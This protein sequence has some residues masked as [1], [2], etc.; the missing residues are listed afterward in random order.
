M[1]CDHLKIL[2]LA[3][4]GEWDR[5]H[6]LIQPYSDQNSCLIHA[7]L[8]RI[9][10]DLSNAQYWYNRAELSMP[11]NTLEQELERLYLLVDDTNK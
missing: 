5:A 3:K 2:N 8:H 11:E 1:I 9:E 4:Q 7:Y 6:Q 10:G